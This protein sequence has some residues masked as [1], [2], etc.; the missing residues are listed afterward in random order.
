MDDEIL[1]NPYG[2]KGLAKIN[3][4]WIKKERIEK[5]RLLRLNLDSKIAINI[6][7][8]VTKLEPAL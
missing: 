1:F 8:I 7:K 3:K 4:D 5:E 6:K 2:E